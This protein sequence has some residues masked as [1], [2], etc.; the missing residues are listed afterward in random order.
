MGSSLGKG[1]IGVLGDGM[2]VP[3]QVSTAVPQI[4]PDASSRCLRRL[5][6]YTQ[7][8]QDTSNSR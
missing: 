7:T 5:Q 2:I 8:L 4:I 6:R 3:C 1:C